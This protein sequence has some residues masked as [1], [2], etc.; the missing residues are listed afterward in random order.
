MQTLRLAL[1]ERHSALAEQLNILPRQVQA[2]SQLIAIRWTLKREWSSE[3]TT[4][5]GDVRALMSKVRT[6]SATVAQ[7]QRSSY[8]ISSAWLPRQAHLS[9]QQAT[10]AALFCEHSFRLRPNPYTPCAV[11]LTMRLRLLWLSRRF[12]SVRECMHD[13][14]ALMSERLMLRHPSA[15]P[16]ALPE[17]K[18][19]LL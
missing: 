2:T 18:A 14:V 13:R 19:F 12:E 7:W 8:R 9:D 16:L 1:R 15:E 5:R 4:I 6:L 11:L 17:G 3:I 10:Q